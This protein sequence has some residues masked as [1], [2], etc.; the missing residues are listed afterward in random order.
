MAPAA[1]PPLPPLCADAGPE[2]VDKDV[3][4]GTA[5]VGAD[6]DVV[7][8]LL[9]TVALASLPAAL[10]EDLM[11]SVEMVDS[12]LEDVDEDERNAAFMLLA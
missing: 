5:P 4:A 7:A 2:G 6:V 8:G 11:S 12:V 1:S 9:G 10:L 3:V